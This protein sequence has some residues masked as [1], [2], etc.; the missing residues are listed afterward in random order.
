MLTLRLGRARLMAKCFRGPAHGRRLHD[1]CGFTV[2]ATDKH[3]KQ[4]LQLALPENVDTRVRRVP[5]KRPFGLQHAA[6]VK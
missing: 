6:G 3:A 2:C 4:L 1:Q 5:V